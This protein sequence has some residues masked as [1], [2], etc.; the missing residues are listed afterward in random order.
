MAVVTEGGKQAV[1]LFKVL[2]NF[3]GYALLEL[4]L[5]TGRTHQI[6]VHLK[7][8]SC[9]VLGDSTYGQGIT[10]KE[11][12]RG[13]TIKRQALHAATIKF[14]HPSSGKEME[15]SSPLPQDMKD[16]LNILKKL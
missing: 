7:N 5:K 15:F 4:N 9:P 2:E 10:E 3:N 12:R 14:I 6:R 8:I 16:T 13:L 1:T 11:R